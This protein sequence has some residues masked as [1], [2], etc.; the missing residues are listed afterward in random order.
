MGF[1]AVLAGSMIGVPPPAHASVPSASSGQAFWAPLQVG[2]SLNASVA[3]SAA[4]RY[5]IIVA[6]P[7]VLAPYV[8]QMRA[9][10]PEII[11]LAYVNGTNQSSPTAFPSSLYLKDAHGRLVESR[12]FKTYLMDFTNPV[13]VE[14][15]VQTCLAAISSAH[16][17]GCHLDVLGTSSLSPGYTTGLPIDPHTGDV[18]TPAE[19]LHGTDALA[20]NVQSAAG[21]SKIIIGNGL[22]DGPHF[23]NV[24]PSSIL[25]GGEAGGVA[26]GWMHNAIDAMDHWPG[27]NEW[28]LNVDML[29][30]GSQGKVILTIT[31]TWGT[32]TTA[33]IEQW[34]QFSL[35]SFLLGSSGR[36]AYS[37]FPTR[38][39]SAIAANPWDAFP[40]GSPTSAYFAA[41]NGFE[42]DFTTGKVLVNPSTSSW[43]VSLGGTY[44]DVAGHHMTTATLQ[45]HTGLILTSQ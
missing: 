6:A 28:K 14:N 39:A 40:I 7:E 24:G 23:Y 5:R 26:E 15:R 1:L 20:A 42:R 19:W 18:F 36:D 45:P 22:G 21:N 13:W 3:A 12:G 41:S 17:D 30:V 31:K 27:V 25:L 35:A 16:L 11:L 43:T 34:H 2:G 37:F 4:R 44:R 29:G 33:L 10:N 32:G 8:S 38:G 9:A